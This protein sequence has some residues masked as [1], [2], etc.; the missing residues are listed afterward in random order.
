MEIKKPQKRKKKKTKIVVKE[1]T[2]KKEYKSSI[3]H[4]V[5]HYMF[6]QSQLVMYVFDFFLLSYDFSH[7]ISVD[8]FHDKKCCN[9]INLFPCIFV[10]FY[11]IGFS[12]K[13]VKTQV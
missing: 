11:C 7:N 8:L 13:L 1:E 4:F 6:H 3:P 10:E 12:I 9:Y 2:V 5:F